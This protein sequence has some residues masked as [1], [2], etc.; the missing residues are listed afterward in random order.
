MEGECPNEEL[1]AA[2]LDGELE[3]LATD[4]VRAHVEACATCLG[5]LAEVVD[6][7]EAAQSEHEGFD[8]YVLGRR[9]GAGAMGIV[10]EAFDPELKRKVAIKLVRASAGPDRAAEH[11][12]MLR[13]AQA[14]ARLA[15]P[16]LVPVLAVGTRDEDLYLVMELIEGPSLRAWL[17]SSAHDWREVLRA[18]VAAGR[19]LAAAHAAGVVHRDFKP[20]N[21]LVSAQGD[22]IAARVRVIDFGL[23]RFVGA[24][25]PAIATIPSGS[26]QL[27]RT[28]AGVLLGT[29]AYM[30]PEQR[31]DAAVDAR[32][33]QFALAVALWE[34]LFGER[35]FS[36]RTHSALQEAIESGKLQRPAA[37]RGVPT[38]V[39]RAL[40]RALAAKPELRFADMTAFVDALE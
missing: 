3:P 39:V 12:R 16:N 26:E 5:L 21:V 35:P 13:E 36:G 22:D 10:H 29:P 23:A 18:Y 11:A 25:E 17:T 19:G 2:Y 28:A 24:V 38:R 31:V 37:R 34:G 8:R 32:A 4:E 14:M 6:D 40:E 30:A 15:H 7:P 33:D 9:L 20:D 1:L 27:E